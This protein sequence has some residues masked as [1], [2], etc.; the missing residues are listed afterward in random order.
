[1]LVPVGI[2]AQTP[3]QK[4]SIEKARADSI[5]LVEQ[6]TKELGGQSGADTSNTTAPAPRATG[7]YM[8]IGFVSLLDGGWSSAK[9][10]QNLQPGDHDPHQNGFTLPNTELTFDGAVDPYFNKK[11]AEGAEFVT[12]NGDVGVWLSGPHSITY[13]DRTGQ[14]QTATARLAGPTLIWTGGNVTYRLEGMASLTDAMAV[15]QSMT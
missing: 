11:G 15:A 5:A 4:D 9:D 2:T 7:G 14:E 6:L 8:N 10:I 3:A 1:V 13:V 12:V